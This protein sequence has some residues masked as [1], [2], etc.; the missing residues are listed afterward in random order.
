MSGLDLLGSGS[1]S[2]LLGS[3]C[4][5]AGHCIVHLLGVW[6][7]CRLGTSRVQPRTPPACCRWPANSRRRAPLHAL[8]GQQGNGNSGQPSGCG[9]SSCACPATSSLHQ[10]CRGRA[11]RRQLR[12]PLHLAVHQRARCVVVGALRM[13]PLYWTATCIA[14]QY[15]SDW[16]HGVAEP[17]HW[18]AC[19]CAQACLEVSAGGWANGQ[20]LCCQWSAPARACLMQR[21]SCP[22]AAGGSSGVIGTGA[23][24]TPGGSATSSGTVSGT[25]GRHRAGS[26]CNVA[27]SLHLSPDHWT[28]VLVTGTPCSDAGGRLF[29]GCT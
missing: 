13:V 2:C 24:S 23:T 9:C 22:H 29:S 21:V 17:V 3:V 28:A 16:H 15:D 14:C 10:H 18:L 8:Q 5:E 7:R 11:C 27:V 19:Q 6:H 26:G 20:V 1:T 4:S 25:G 12:R